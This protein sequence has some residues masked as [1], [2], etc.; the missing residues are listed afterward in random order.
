MFYTR[1]LHS[2]FRPKYAWK[3]RPS[4]VCCTTRYRNKAGEARQRKTTGLKEFLK[5]ELIVL[6][7]IDI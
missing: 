2:I 3:M 7:K 1:Q 5:A 4:G 6:Y